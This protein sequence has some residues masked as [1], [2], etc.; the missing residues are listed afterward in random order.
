VAALPTKNDPGT[1]LM[2]A[3]LQRQP[4]NMAY[5]VFVPAILAVGIRLVHGLRL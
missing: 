5:Y 2:M 1:S 4:S 3:R